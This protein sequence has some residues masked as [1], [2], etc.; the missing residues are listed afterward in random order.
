MTSA[1]TTLW[2]RLRA[3]QL[4][5]L[6]F[7]RQHAIGAYILDFCCL[8]LKLTV[9]VDGGSHLEQEAY[10][11]RRTEWLKSKGWVVSR[12]TNIEVE[13]QIDLV[14]SEII[15]IANEIGR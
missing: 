7:R 14:L 5:G 1:E 4:N 2:K 9:E 11:D 12:F 15:R 6:R 13:T 10:D 3:G 8:E